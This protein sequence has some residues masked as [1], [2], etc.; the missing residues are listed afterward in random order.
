MSRPRIEMSDLV[1]DPFGTRAS[2]RRQ[3]WLADADGAVA[4]VTRDRVRELLADPHPDELTPAD[5]AAVPH[6]AFGHGAHFCL[7]AALA[8]AEL[9]DGLSA[10]AERLEC[11]RVESGT[12][13]KPPLGINGPEVLPISFRIRAAM[14]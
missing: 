1:A 4:V 10:L 2:A 9:Q 13:W 11:P 6:L 5:N 3:G 7:G 14:A 8:R 12:V